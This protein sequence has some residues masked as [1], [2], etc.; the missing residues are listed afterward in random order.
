[1]FGSGCE[2][3]RWSVDPKALD[4]P[5]SFRWTQ[6]SQVL[7]DQEVSR[8]EHSLIAHV[9][10]TR[11]QL[12]K[13]IFGEIQFLAFLY[14]FILEQWWPKAAIFDDCNF[15]WFPLYPGI[16]KSSAAS[17][18]PT[19]DSRNA[20]GQICRQTMPADHLLSLVV[21]WFLELRMKASVIDHYRSF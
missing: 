15:P 6:T 16:S 9:F 10:H 17:V 2:V 18:D 3:L 7:W 21:P 4:S 8:K 5:G 12:Y 13:C 20:T 11:M 14:Y 19:A 1:M